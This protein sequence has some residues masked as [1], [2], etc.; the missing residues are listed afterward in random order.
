M[1]GILDLMCQRFVERAA[2]EGG[3]GG[4]G[5]AMDRWVDG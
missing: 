5:G 1:E 2:G 4:G 3:G